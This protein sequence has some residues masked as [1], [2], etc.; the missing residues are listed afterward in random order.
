V[1]PRYCRRQLF[2]LTKWQAS[3]LCLTN[4]T[5]HNSDTT[6]PNAEPGTNSPVLFAYANKSIIVAKRVREPLGN[7]SISVYA[8]T[9]SVFPQ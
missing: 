1:T 9:Q 8:V 3:Q 2:G 6:V 5:L 4:L 7:A